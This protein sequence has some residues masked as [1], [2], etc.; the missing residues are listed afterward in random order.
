M[1]ISKKPGGKH[2]G[3]KPPIVQPSD[4]R[5]EPGGVQSVEV[6]MKVLKAL[7]DAG[8][9]QTL[10][11][12]AEAT[13]MPSAKAHRY[14][15]SLVRA[16]FVERDSMSSH[17][18]LG[19]E[20]LRVGLVALS[21]TD[22]VETASAELQSLR[23]RI[24]G[25]LLL[26]IWGTSGPTIVRWIESSRA[27]TVNVRSGSRMPLLRSA[28]GQV[29]A[30]YLPDATV[31][32]F[33]E[34]ELAEMKIQKMPLPSDKQL[35]S[36]LEKV[37]SLGLGH[38]EGEM[39]PGVLAL[40]APLFDHQHE[41]AGVIAALGPAGFFDNS[42]DGETARQLKQTAGIISKRLGANLAGPDMA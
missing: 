15:A 21:R 9:G 31:R 38:T 32:P 7:A 34:Q 20:A 19:A 24:S 1:S 35:Q 23:D 12:I 5:P 22:V 29:F 14:L 27:V 10:G 2:S 26:A 3:S 37:R 30:A 16:G 11:R 13:R 4:A 17:Y 8:G 33:I 36:R 39:L 40:A 28:T 25:A 42:L 18:V 41:L 6:G